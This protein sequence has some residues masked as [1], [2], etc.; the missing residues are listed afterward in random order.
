MNPSYKKPVLY[1]LFSLCLLVFVMVVIGGVTRLT[2]SG[3]SMVEWK[4]L[5][6]AI[7]PL[8]EADWQNVYAKYQQF[9]EYKI[10][11]N[12]MSLSEFKFIFYWEYFHRLT[13]RLLGLVFLLPFVFFLI[14]RAFDKQ[15]GFKIFVGF[16]LG[17][18]QGLMG[19]YMV[20]SGLVDRP[21]V[22]H[23][24]LAAHL[25]LAFV[26]FAYL[27][28][29]YLD[30]KNDFKSQKHPLFK[31]GWVWTGLVLLQIV[32]GAFVAGKN[33]GIGYNTFPKMGQEWLPAQA[34]M[35]SPTWINFFEN[36]IGLQFTHRWLAA[37]LV[38]GF[39]LL[40]I[41]IK[42]KGRIHKAKLFL[43]G[44]LSLQFLLGVATLLAMVPLHL[45]ALHQ[46]GA[47]FL[48]ACSIYLNH[49]MKY[50]TES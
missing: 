33:A 2:N 6:G 23:Y 34:F 46:A 35:M 16:I 39:V 25:T 45:A 22:S 18:L 27:Y 30:I 50:S 36:N 37:L 12:Q 43:G 5:L 15:L 4:P 11:N 47:F 40:S 26:I 41:I 19:W 17:G 38:L 9:P 10:I 20:K 49:A 48:F 1:W 14:R 21:D 8:S 42:S 3:L 44:A 13:G 7:P 24:R 31:L 28:W 32:Y 29:L